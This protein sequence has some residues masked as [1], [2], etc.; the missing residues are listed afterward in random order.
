[1][2]RRLKV[3]SLSI[4]PKKWKKAEN[5][6]KVLTFLDTAAKA[7]A[8][9]ALT[10]EG[11]LEG[12]C[13]NEAIARGWGERMLEVAEPLDGPC[14]SLVREK[15]RELGLPVLLGLAERVGDEA[16]N[17]AALITAEGEIADKYH[18]THLAEGYDPAWNFNRPGGELRPIR[19]PFGVVAVAICHDRMFPEVLRAQALQGAEMIAIPSY[20]FYR[21][22]NDMVTVVRAAENGLPAVFCHPRR[23]LIVDVQTGPGSDGTFK[24]GAVV[25]AKGRTD[26]VTVGEITLADRSD[27]ER[28]PWHLRRPGLY[29]G[30]FER[31]RGSVAHEGRHRV[32][33]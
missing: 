9:F 17:T 29:N 23:S 3:A 33:A 8:E 7:G 19:A 18:K 31:V 16:F 22:W 10:P 27:S 24:E 6:H 21:H 5:T 14:V 12:Y 4:L 25:V 32:T 26:S 1:M 13:V 28:W 15:A 20:G 2:A 30:I 11:V